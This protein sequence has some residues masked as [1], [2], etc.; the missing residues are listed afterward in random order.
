MAFAAQWHPPHNRCVRFAPAVAG[1]HATLATGRPLRPTRTG[2]SPAGPRQ[3][4]PGAQAIHLATVRKNGL[5]RCARNDGLIAMAQHATL[6]VL[7]RLQQ[8]LAIRGPM[9]TPAR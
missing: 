6:S 9:S 7:I 3:L 5:L 1:D 2:L 4:L 8:L